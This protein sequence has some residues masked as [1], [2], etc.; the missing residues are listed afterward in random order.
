MTGQL[1]DSAQLENAK[2]LK[3]VVKSTGP[4]LG[5]LQKTVELKPTNI[6]LKLTIFAYIIN[7]LVRDMELYWYEVEE[8]LEEL[9]KH[10]SMTIKPEVIFRQENWRRK[11]LVFLRKPEAIFLDV[12]MECHDP[13]TGV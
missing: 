2:D 11:D 3:N 12:S 4:L 13:Q 1:Q 10:Y 8:K 6:S 5:I 7:L 9:I